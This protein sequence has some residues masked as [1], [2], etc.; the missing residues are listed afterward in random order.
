MIWNDIK[1]KEWAENGGMDPFDPESINPASIDLRLGYHIRYPKEEG[2]SDPI[3][4]DKAPWVIYPGQIVLLHTLEFTKIPVNAVALLFLKS[5]AGRN[6]LEHL[7]AGYG[8]PGFHG[9]WTL[10][11]INHWPY[12]KYLNPLMKLVHLVL[13]DSCQPEVEY[14]LVGH[15]QNQI[16]STKPWLIV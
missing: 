14:S 5:T 2:W 6:G 10:E 16:G 8:D 13:V 15:Y 9:Q 1:L 11:I 12:P 4:T 7:H 3:G